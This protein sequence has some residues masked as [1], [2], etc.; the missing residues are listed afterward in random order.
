MIEDEVIAAQL[1]LLVSPVVTS[2]ENYYRQLG[3][4]DRILTLP[5]MLAAVLTKTFRIELFMDWFNKWN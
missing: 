3:M 1:E 4:R 2:Q 5:L